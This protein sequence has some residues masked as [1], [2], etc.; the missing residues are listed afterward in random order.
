MTY[1]FMIYKGKHP[2]PTN[3]DNQMRDTMGEELL[4]RI[5]YEFSSSPFID[6]TFQLASTCNHGKIKGHGL[7]LKLSSAEMQ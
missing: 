7:T 3:D 1:T 6:L 2:Q 5:P 4:N